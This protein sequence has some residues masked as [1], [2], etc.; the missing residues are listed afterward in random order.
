MR[1]LLL[2]VLVSL[3]VTSGA[4]SG[5]PSA[6]A[7]SLQEV[8][9][10][11]LAEDGSQFCREKVPETVTRDSGTLVITTVPRF[12]GVRVDVDGRGHVSGSDGCLIVELSHGDHS[13]AVPKDGEGE[14]RQVVES[15]VR[16]VR[17]QWEQPVTIGRVPL[18]LEVEVG[19]PVCVLLPSQ[20]TPGELAPK[21][22]DESGLLAISTVP[23]TANVL[24]Y[25]DGYELFSDEDGCLVVELTRGFHHVA[26]P[27]VYQ[28]D[29]T[30]RLVFGRWDDVWD[31]ERDVK[32]G[33]AD[34]VRDLGLK[35][36]HPVR[37]EF[38]D[39]SLIPLDIS[40]IQSAN[41]FTSFG[42]TLPL[43]EKALEEDDAISFDRVW[44]S[45]NRLRRISVGLQSDDNIYVFREVWV[46][47]LNVVQSGEIGYVPSLEPECPDLSSPFSQKCDHWR[48]RLLLFPFRVEL[49]SFIFGQPVTADIEVHLLNGGEDADPV[50]TSQ[51]S[52]Q[53]WVTW[54]QVPRGDYEIRVTGGGLSTR[55]P[56]IVTGPKVEQITVMTRQV[57]W[58]VIPVVGLMFLTVVLFV[59][60]PRWRLGLAAIWPLLFGF[61]L[62]VPSL[63]AALNRP[64][65]ASVTATYTAD[66][67]F[68]GIDAHVRN[69]SV[70]PVDQAYCAP[71]FELRIPNSGGIWS[72]TYESPDFHDVEASKECRT[73]RVSPGSSRAFF[74]ST[75]G[76]EWNL[77][78][79]LPPPGV[80]EA[81]VRVFDIPAGAIDIDLRQGFAPFLSFG[82]EERPFN[83]EIP[84][85]NPFED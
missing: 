50:L 11:E 48:V 83:E 70:I 56:T 43:S 54:P 64:L 16:T 22:D 39:A 71:D 30:T 42:E 84:F 59:R 58:F 74:S 49:R 53:G 79:D 23:R 47:D 66:G 35:I 27:D 26:V 72:A 37:F 38:F 25:I 33:R 68:T 46:D 62:S 4:L 41:L 32:I 36:Q 28:L 14:E 15:K 51:T 31:I 13:V 63:G 12:A 76:Q 67:A 69:N 65:S 7:I 9:P 17:G 77:S 55:T 19:P 8:Q 61:M 18:E 10:R 6:A 5:A 52:Q 78:G 82:Q 3:V 40:R 80:Y 1:R 60:K 73:H 34:E 21:I 57:L 29:D 85:T 44:L 75:Q 20:S 24:V 2:F 45:A 81:F